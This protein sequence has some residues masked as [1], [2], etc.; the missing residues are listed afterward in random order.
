M[1]TNKEYLKS[2]GVLCPNCSAEAS[3]M[4]QGYTETVCNETI[5][6]IE[7][8]TCGANWWEVF[9]LVRYEGLELDGNEERNPPD[10]QPVVLIEVRGGVASILECP[11]WIEVEIRDHDASPDWYDLE[12]WHIKEY[13]DSDLARLHEEHLGEIEY[14]AAQGNDSI[15]P[16]LDKIM[17]FIMNEIE[18]RKEKDGR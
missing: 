2:E 17:G 18:S 9:R 7:C 16:L 13:S 1:L 12:P 14:Q 11:E 10:P 15:I 3:Q 5:E 6:S 4:G 8:L